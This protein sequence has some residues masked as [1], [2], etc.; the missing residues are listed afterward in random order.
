MGLA[1]SRRVAVVIIILLVAAGVVSAMG[2]RE[3]PLLEA[4][5]L[6]DAKRYDEAIKYLTD[7]MK[8]YPERFDEAQTRLRRINEIRKAYNDTAGKLLDQMV[9]DPT[10]QKGK[11]DKIG[12]LERLQPNPNDQVKS[13]VQDTKDAALFTYNNAQREDIMAKGRQLTASGDYPGAAA[14]YAGGYV[15]YRPEFGQEGH[16]EATLRAVIAAVDSGS[17][18]SRELAA[19]RQRLVAAAVAM[20]DA[21]GSGDPA[22]VDAAW[23]AFERESRVLYG[24]RM[25]AYEAGWYLHDLFQLFREKNKDLND[26]SFL[27]FA[28]RFTLGTEI[29]RES[30]GIVGAVDA[31]WASIQ[32]QVRAGFDRGL[33]A[34]AG[35]ADANLERGNFTEAKTG[36][37]LYAAHADR[38]LASL[39]LWVLYAPDDLRGRAIV[40]SRAALPDV[41]ADLLR[42]RALRDASLA[43]S[44]MSDSRARLAGTA[45]ALDEYA[46]D[47]AAPGIPAF[48]AALSTFDGFRKS[49]AGE[50]AF[51]GRET[52]A[53]A[54]LKAR[55]TAWTDAGFGSADPVVR[56]TALDARLESTGADAAATET[57]AVVMAAGYEYGIY[58]SQ[59]ASMV[60][61]IAETDEFIQGKKGDVFLEKY[62]TKARNILD[63]NGRK[64]RDLRLQLESFQTRYSGEKPYVAAS[65]E[66]AAWLDKAAALDAATAGSAARNGTALAAAEEL[67]KLAKKAR[68]EGNAR[69]SESKA[70]LAKQDFATAKQRLTQATERFDESLRN[71]YDPEL[72]AGQDRLVAGLQVE[73]KTAENNKVIDDTR[74]LMDQARALMDAESYADARNRYLEARARWSTTHA[75]NDP[76]AD[77]EAQIAYVQTIISARSDRTVPETDA[78]YPEISQL[79]S[80]AKRYYTEGLAFKKSGNIDGMER[81]FAAALKKI[82][83]VKRIFPYNQEARVLELRISQ[84]NE[85]ERF[86]L[87]FRNLVNDA[88]A[89]LDKGQRDAATRDALAMLEVL[90]A[91]DP[92]YPGIQDQITRAEIILGIKDPPANPK[93]IADARAQ[94]ASARRLVDSGD[95]GQAQQLLLQA[96]ARLRNNRGDRTAQAIDTEAGRLL[97]EI[98]KRRGASVVLELAAA[99]RARLNEVIGFFQGGDYLNARNGLTQLFAQYP[100]ARNYQACID[101]DARLKARGY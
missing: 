42:L 87:I 47:P 57:R 20:A 36:Y 1:L 10:N 96:R 62:P 4:D 49:A 97:D 67:I 19:G 70:A 48:G 69:I 45:A 9:Q 98:A 71:E 99:A 29:S 72:L 51:A 92:K 54:E 79:L 88:K 30:E 11:L 93:D 59:H 84:S 61:A 55:F 21:A 26:N 66:L 23:P 43:F 91:L 65:A 24:L 44:R 33:Q 100:E 78:L 76:N 32:T 38:A 34:V 37:A 82:Q 81:S 25:R 39:A 90:K 35:E 12:E 101:I 46:P 58:E 68:D 83:D 6:I 15:L 27:S 95:L 28:Y 80:L 41:A 2:T 7:F 14:A 8:K 56:Q 52:A 31:F 75:D 60:S 73:I 85:P 94:V 5:R 22:R 89:Q 16:D 40:F 13:F 17:A 77:L 86:S 18:V 3:D 63:P 64:L 50:V 74:K 53:A